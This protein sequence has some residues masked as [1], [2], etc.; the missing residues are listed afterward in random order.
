MLLRT[1][2][3]EGDI[4]L[5]MAGTIGLCVVVPKINEGNINQAIARIVTI[6]SVNNIYLSELLNSSIGR[7]QS[8]QLSRPAVQ[9]NINLDEIKQ[10]QIPLPPLSIQNE[11]AQH[12]QE[13]RAK[14]KAL[15][16][17]AKEILEKAKAEV[18]KMI[19]GD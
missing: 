17:E 10:I 5:S 9:S 2:L 3:K 15:E 4:L 19:L 1:Q 6:N 14:A 18:E 16:N 12:I 7:T 8:Q 13:I 11:I